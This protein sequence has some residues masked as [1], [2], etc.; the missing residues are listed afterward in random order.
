VLRYAFKG[1]GEKQ[2]EKLSESF[3]DLPVLPAVKEK[4]LSKIK[5]CRDSPLSFPGSFCYIEKTLRFFP[6]KWFQF[7]PSYLFPERNPK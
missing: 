5:K 7:L 2:I 6:Q 3:S 4:K 1:E